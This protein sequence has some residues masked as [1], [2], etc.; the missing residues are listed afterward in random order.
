MDAEWIVIELFLK[1]KILGKGKK[2][3]QFFYKNNIKIL[4]K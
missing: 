1:K 4:L 2:K 3:L